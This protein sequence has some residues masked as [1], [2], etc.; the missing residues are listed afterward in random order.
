MAHVVNPYTP[1]SLMSD[2]NIAHISLIQGPLTVVISC[3][4]AWLSFHINHIN[5]NFNLLMI[6]RD[7]RPI[8]ILEMRGT[9]IYEESKHKKIFRDYKGEVEGSEVWIQGF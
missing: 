9:W 1:L 5:L 4:S 6:P 3:T 7:I 2:H 8:V